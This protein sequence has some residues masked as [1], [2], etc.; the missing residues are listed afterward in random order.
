VREEESE[1]R[2]QIPADWELWE[3]E[4]LL[5]RMRELKRLVK[6][7]VLLVGDR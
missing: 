7:A 3:R 2:D 1:D 6:E 4:W 5:P